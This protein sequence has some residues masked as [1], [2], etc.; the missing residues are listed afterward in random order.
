MQMEHQRQMLNERLNMSEAVVTERIGKADLDKYV[1]DFKVHAEKDPALWG[2]LYSQASPYAWMTREID[3]LRGLDEIGDDP[4][5]YEQKLR[6]RWEAEALGQPANGGPRPSSV[7]G[8]APSLANVRSVAGRTTA[9]F[10]GPPSMDDIL[11][12]PQQARR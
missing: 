9:T 5:A 8:M 6:A 10:T 1:A 2:K 11:R 12:R 4:K 3:R 7:A